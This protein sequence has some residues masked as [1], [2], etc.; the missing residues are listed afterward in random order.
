[1][2]RFR[3]SIAGAGLVIAAGLIAPSAAFADGG[4]HGGTSN[5]GNNGGGQTINT[6]TLGNSGSNMSNDHD[7]DHSV[8]L[9]ATGNTGVRALGDN[10]EH[11]DHGKRA[12]GDILRSALA[13][14]IPSDA[15]IFAVAP[16]GIAWTLDRGSV[17]VRASGRLEVGVRG[18]VLMATGTN[19]IPDI[20][21]SVYC[22]G[23][24]AATTLP[25]AFSPSGNAEIETT[26]TLPSTCMVPA[27]LLHPATGSLSSNVL[28]STYI[29]FNGSAA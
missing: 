2:H 26:L 10:E 19:P 23:V 13:P 15:P 12:N 7:D 5:S 20:A 1:M 24:V 18:L 16:G 25:V 11:G 28:I 29:A 6:T 8:T 4:G 27:V 17:R 14:S 22:N 21:A 3:I 9:G